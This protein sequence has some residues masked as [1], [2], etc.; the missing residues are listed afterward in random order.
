M[1]RGFTRTSRCRYAGVANLFNDQMKLD[2]SLGHVKKEQYNVPFV[3]SEQRGALHEGRTEYCVAVR[4]LMIP[5]N[6]HSGCRPPQPHMGLAYNALYGLWLWLSSFI[7]HGAV[8]HHGPA[9]SLPAHQL[10]PSPHQSARTPTRLLDDGTD[11]HRPPAPA[12]T[13]TC[14]TF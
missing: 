1:T 10:L 7:G 12:F 8:C 2:Y 11:C 5:Y 6:V 13:F 4:Y 3:L 14:H 9:S